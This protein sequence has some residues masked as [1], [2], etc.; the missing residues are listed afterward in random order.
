MNF[1][2]GA[3][4]L[5]RCIVT[6]GNLGLQLLWYFLQ[7]IVSAWY[8]ISVVG[9]LFESYF[10]SWGVLK[11]YKSL[12]LK[13]VRYL[14][15]VIE[16]EEAYQISKVVKL[17]QWLDS[18]GV[19]NVCLYDMNG[20]LKK[21]KETIFQKLK[22][23]KSIEDISEVVT[24]HAPGHMTLEFLSYVDGKEAVAKAANLIFVENMK[25]HNLGG[26]LDVPILLESHLNE[27]LQIVGSKGPEPDLLLVYGPVR[28]HLGFPAWR[29]PYTEIIHM[30][31]L[32]F[33]RYGSLRKAIYNYTKVHQNYGS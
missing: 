19:K 20:V 11:K 6:I 5:P 3:H 33:M 16:S 31:S 10:I 1:R 29:L 21:S 25:R 12:H 4:K 14:A 17:L 9:N 13:N 15:I 27:A 7:I 32:N 8:Y 23:A 30:G 22:N 2:D 24:H 26:E 28:S 18:I